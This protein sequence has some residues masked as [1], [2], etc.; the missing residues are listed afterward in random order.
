VIPL[1]DGQVALVVGDVA[2]HGIHAA[3]IMGQ[4]RTATATLAHLGRPPGEIMGELSRVAAGHGEE[5]SV[6]CL[7][8]L[9]D[10][11]S[12]RCRFTGAGH[13]RQFCASPAAG[14]EFIDMPAGG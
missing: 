9:Y 10:P 8:A 1:D 5:T 2:G 4:L 14:E 3:A 12:R 7:Y 11:A 13:R 6:T